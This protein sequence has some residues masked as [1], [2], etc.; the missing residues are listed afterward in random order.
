MSI[1]S[2]RTTG[3]SNP[4]AIHLECNSGLKL[5]SI[6]LSSDANTGVLYST[7]KGK[8]GARYVLVHPVSLG[9]SSLGTLSLWARRLRVPCLFGHVVSQGTLFLRAH[10]FPSM[11]FVSLCTFS[12]GTSSL[13]TRCLSGLVVSLGTLFLRA[14]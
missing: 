1:F 6:S 9:T 12:L 5:Y 11:T 3:T 2:L 7:K 4:I 14:R 13:W 8:T 10:L